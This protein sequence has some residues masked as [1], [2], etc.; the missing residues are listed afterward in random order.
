MSDTDQLVVPG[1]PFADIDCPLLSVI[2]GAA[3]SVDQSDLDPVFAYLFY[4]GHQRGTLL[5]CLNKLFSELSS[6]VSHGVSIFNVN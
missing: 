4:V 6:K 1:A 2:E 5:G 3:G